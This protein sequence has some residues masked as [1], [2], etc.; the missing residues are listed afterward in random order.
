[1]ADGARQTVSGAVHRINEGEGMNVITMK[2]LVAGSF[3]AAG[4]AL[5]AVGVN[6]GAANAAPAAPAVSGPQY[7]AENGPGR[8]HGHG[9]DDDWW[10]DNHGPRRWDPVDACIG[11]QGPFG[12]VEGSACI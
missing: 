10:W 8:G 11:V 5:T 7:I 4:M 2:S 1:L 3:L 6:A 9:H 12:Y